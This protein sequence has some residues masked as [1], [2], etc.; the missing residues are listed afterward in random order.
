MEYQSGFIQTQKAPLVRL[1]YIETNHGPDTPLVL[2]LHGFPETSHTWQ[3]YLPLLSQA[4]FHSVALDLRG[5]SQSSHPSGKKQ[6]DIDLLVKDIKQVIEYFRKPTF[7]VGH[8][9]G[10]IITLE[11]AEKYPELCKGIVIIN[12][13]HARTMLRNMRRS[14]KLSIKQSAKFWYALFFQLPLLPEALLRSSNYRPL[15]SMIKRQAVTH[16]AYSEEDLS[17]YRKSYEKGL[18][19]ALNYYRRN[20]F[21]LLFRQK[22]F[23]ERPGLLIWGEKDITLHREI[24]SGMEKFFKKGLTKRYFKGASHWVHRERMPEVCAEMVTFFRS[25]NSKLNSTTLHRF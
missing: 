20:L 3:E 16:E 19:P 23:I 22:S 12:A 11:L 5:Y 18:T 4:G 1:H 24:T 14:L 6:Y 10:G 25:I 7:L 9:W 2:M 15:S 17:E 21:R 13:P 8:D